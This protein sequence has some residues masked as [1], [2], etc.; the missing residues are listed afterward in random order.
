MTPPEVASTIT[1][2]LLLGWS[3]AWPPGPVNAEMI[4]RGLTRGFAPAV[5][6]GFG[7][8]TADFLWALA[9]AGGAGALAGL[10]GVRP[11]LAGVSLVLLLFLAWTFLSGAFLAWQRSRHPALHTVGHPA[12]HPIPGPVVKERFAGTRGGYLLGLTMALASPWNIAFWL[13]VIGSQAGSQAGGPNGGALSFRISLLLAGA[14]VFAAAT[15]TVVLCS[16]VRLGARFAT[17]AWEITTQA[18]TGVLMIYFAVRLLL[19]LAGG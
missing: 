9:V 11:A 16:A 15:W 13:A 12:G 8:C 3:V 18:A 6:V 4:R 17:P 10:P 19:R 1:A 5:A 7:A 2:G 14:V